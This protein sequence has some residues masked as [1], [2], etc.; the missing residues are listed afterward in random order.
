MQGDH[1]SFPTKMYI[2]LGFH[3]NMDLRNAEIGAVF[4]AIAVELWL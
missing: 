4:V 2:P 1:T 3:H